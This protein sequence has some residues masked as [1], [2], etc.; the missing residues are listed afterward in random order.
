MYQRQPG[1]CRFYAAS[2]VRIARLEPPR[3]FA[4]EFLS[5]LPIRDY[6]AEGRLSAEGLAR[7]AEPRGR[8]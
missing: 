6:R 4:Y 1:T 5:A 2:R 8:S 7:E 3:R